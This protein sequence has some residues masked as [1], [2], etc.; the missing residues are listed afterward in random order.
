MQGVFMMILRGYSIFKQVLLIKYDFEL[1]VVQG[2]YV[3]STKFT[4]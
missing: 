3:I 4:I 1:Y 2:N